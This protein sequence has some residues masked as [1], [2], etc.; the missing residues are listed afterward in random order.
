MATYRDKGQRNFRLYSGT[1]SKPMSMDFNKIKIGRASVQGEIAALIR[2]EYSK[3]RKSNVSFDRGT[4][5]RAI[6]TC[7]IKQLREISEYFYRVS[8]I[9][10]RLCRY[11]AYLY[12]YD[13]YVTPQRYDKKIK[14]DKIIEGWVKSLTYLENSNLKLA[15][16]DIAL[17]VLKNGCYYGLVMDRGDAAFLQE[18][19]ANYCRSRFKINGRYLVE[20]NIKYFDDAFSDVK[21]RNRVLKLFPKEFEKAYVSYKNGKLESD[22]SGD[23]KG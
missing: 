1:E 21:Y 8:G 16:G 19:P 3:R 2:E 12:K 7:D 18:L 23:D 17:K 15:F 10:S 11:M 20:F 13:W 5:M 6:E 14:D 9:Y 4:I 22:F